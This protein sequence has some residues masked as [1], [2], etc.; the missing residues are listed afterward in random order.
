MDCQIHSRDGRRHGRVSDGKHDLKTQSLSAG[1]ESNDSRTH[2]IESKETFHKGD[3]NS[4]LRKQRLGK[5]EGLG[6]QGLLNVKEWNKKI[7]VQ[8]WLL[9][10]TPGK[11]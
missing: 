11:H 2:R 8:S 5:A 3:G 7:Q 4:G 1:I 6:Y 10:M 9:T